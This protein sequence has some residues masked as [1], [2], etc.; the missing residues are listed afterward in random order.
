MNQP[1]VIGDHIDP[2]LRD[3]L[4]QVRKV[5]SR[6]SNVYSPFLQMLE[7]DP[8]RRATIEQVKSHP[9]FSNTYVLS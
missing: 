2:L 5:T 7:K 1:L 4:H 8:S 9:W 3:L 6:A